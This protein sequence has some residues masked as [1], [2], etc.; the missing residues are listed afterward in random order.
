M[1]LCGVWLVIL[2]LWG[3]DSEDFTPAL[4]PLMLAIVTTMGCILSAW[5]WAMAGGIATMVGA[6]TVLISAWY[7]ISASSNTVDWY[8]LAVTSLP[9]FATGLL[10]LVTHRYLRSDTC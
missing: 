10:F 8:L 6:V 1:I 5:G 3:T 2:M 9:F 7:A 4:I